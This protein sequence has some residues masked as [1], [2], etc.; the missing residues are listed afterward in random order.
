MAPPNKDWWKLAAVAAVGVVLAGL[1]TVIAS[2]FA[3]PSTLAGPVA[4]PAVTTTE[5]LITTTT[6]SLFVAP[7]AAASA[8]TLAAEPAVLEVAESI[9]DFGEG[10][11]SVNFD[12][13]NSGEGDGSWSIASSDPNVTTDPSD[14]QISPGEVV[15]V[16]ATF[17][18]TTAAEG[19]LAAVLALTWDDNELQIVV[20]GIQADNPVII[21]PKAT[22]STVL[23]QTTTGCSPSKTT[24]TARI[25]DTSELAEVIVRWSKG[26]SI[27][28]TP[29]SAVDEENYQAVIG[30][31]AE[32]VSPNAKIVAT[33]VFD[34]A[35]G[36]ALS[37]TVAPCA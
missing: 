11:T 25:K 24:V 6:Q 5:A 18:R 26:G 15:A 2:N 8:T 12:L 21:A 37:L 33:D 28:E 13:T 34:N 4:A 20:Q 19:E 7:V 36:A 27:V 32:V 35:G 17:D 14:G 3:P 29:M 16:S 22:P 23:A 30:P 31:F 9:L 1:G 10:D